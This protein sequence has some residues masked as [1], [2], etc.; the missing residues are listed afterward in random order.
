M[1]AHVDAVIEDLGLTDR[2]DAIRDLWGTFDP[3][4]ASR[5]LVASVRAAGT[6]C[7]LATNQDTLR[8]SYMRQRLG[9]DDLLDGSYY[10]CEVGA[11]KPDARYF[12]HIA[13]E[14]GVAPR[15]LVFVDDLA[16]NVEA[17]TELGLQ[18]VLW[19][20]EQDIAVLKL[21][22]AALEVPF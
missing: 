14:L 19:H 12:L 7:Y 1:G 20:H 2:R 4:P 16:G 15:E 9:Y 11:A 8:A 10:S 5:D 3:L 13:D 21:R 22:L 17:A 6:P 18:G